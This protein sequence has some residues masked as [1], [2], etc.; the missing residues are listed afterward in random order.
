MFK[1]FLS[2]LFCSVFCIGCCVCVPVHA[3]KIRQIGTEIVVEFIG[4]EDIAHTVG[5]LW[6]VYNALSR[7]SESSIMEAA[8]ALDLMVQVLHANG[9]GFEESRNGTP[10]ACLLA[11]AILQSCPDCC[12]EALEPDGKG[13]LMHW[14]HPVICG[15]LRDAAYGFV[16][17]FKRLGY[18]EGDNNYL[19]LRFSGDLITG[20]PRNSLKYVMGHI[21]ISFSRGEFWAAVADVV[22]R[23]LYEAYM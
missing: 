4:D 8:D 23:I 21:D 9:V 1:K 12:E 3:V 15:K 17:S 20:S 2:V 6:E 16:E 5:G 19:S 11:G 14:Y 22:M 10:V 7:Y 18:M 13:R